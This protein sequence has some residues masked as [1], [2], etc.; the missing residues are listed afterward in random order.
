MI[1]EDIVSHKKNEI[2]ELKN[3]QP[4]D[5]LKDT[6]GKLGPTRDFK[7]ALIRLSSEGDSKAINIIAEIKKASPSRGII[8]GDFNPLKIAKAYEENGAV[9]ISVLTEKKYFQGDLKYLTQIR[10]ATSIPLLDKDFII[11]PYQIYLA[12]SYGADAVL[13]ITAI[14]SDRELEEYLALSSQL[15]LNALV[16]V[17]TLE[18]LKRVL[19][20][21]AQIIGINNRNLENYQVCT[22]TSLQLI[23]YIP[24]EKIVV[25]ESGI[26][27]KEI[28]LSLQKEGIDAFLIGEALM[29]E[30]NIGKKLR[31]LL[32]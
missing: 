7:R 29:K 18:E 10:K 11:D 5:E 20:T 21:D 32:N 3:E 30:E 26:D 19:S 31:E 28:I 4:E 14:L 1:L 16:E 23:K 27:N 22:D 15:G 12:R 8:R 24:D 2:S 9:A 6:L 13:L 17:H 25:S